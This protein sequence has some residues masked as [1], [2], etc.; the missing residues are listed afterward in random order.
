MKKKVIKNCRPVSV[1]PFF[2]KIFEKVMY[3]RV[4][5]FITKHKILYELQFGFRKEHSTAMALTVLNDKISSSLDNGD[6][7]L[8]VFLDFSKAFDCVNHKILLTK[9]ECYGIRG[10]ALQWFRSYLTNRKQYVVYNNINS[11]LR[12]ITCGVPQGSILGPLLFLLYINDIT[13]A[14]TKLFPILYADDSNVFLSGKD[15]TKLVDTMNE[16]LIKL[17]KWVEINKL[18]L[19]IPKTQCMV[20][21]LNNVIIEGKVVVKG[22]PVCV[23]KS[24]KFLGVLIDSKL[25]WKQHINYIKGKIAKALGI[26]CKARRLLNTS[27]LRTVYYSF[28]FP[29]LC[30]C[31]EVWGAARKKHISPLIVQ[32]KRAIRMIS[33]AGYREHSLP[34][35][36]KLN[37]LT[38][39]ELYMQRVGLFMFKYYHH[40]LPPA[41]LNMFQ[42]NN[43]F[44]N[45]TT[46]SGHCLS[47][48]RSRITCFNQSIRVKG[49][50]IWNDI[51]KNVQINTSLMVYKQALT[52]KIIT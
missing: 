8:G 19:N 30:Y 3:N 23:V 36:R 44:H 25:E 47:V 37:L 20:F 34:L 21:S 51:I 50:I 14:S 4:S 10:I 11:N 38:L 31:I 13:N 35:F 43:S 52:K 45:Y 33:F 39:K 29:Y 7:V 18:S 12:D 49:V 6:H 42:T 1:L 2:S 32:H 9:L 16:E 27:T 46:R 41:F 40:K 48:P 22:N 15:I 28:L 26:L 24:T 17:V 5:D